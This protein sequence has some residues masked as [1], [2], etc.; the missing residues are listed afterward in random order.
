MSV[1][2]KIGLYMLNHALSEELAHSLES[3]PAIHWDE[4]CAAET[5]LYTTNPKL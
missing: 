1:V 5:Y 3:Q 2:E 4:D